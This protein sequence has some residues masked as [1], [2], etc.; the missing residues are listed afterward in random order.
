MNITI[1]RPNRVSLR[2]VCLFLAALLLVLSSCALSSVRPDVPRDRPVPR[3]PDQAVKDEIVDTFERIRQNFRV[4]SSSYEEIIREL[5]PEL[6]YGLVNRGEAILPE[7]LSLI[8]ENLSN[9]PGARYTM[10]CRDILA[11]MGYTEFPHP[12]G[13]KGWFEVHGIAFYEQYVG[14]YRPPEKPERAWDRA[15][16]YCLEKGYFNVIPA[17]PSVYIPEPADPNNPPYL[18]WETMLGTWVAWDAYY[19]EELGFIIEENPVDH[20]YWDAIMYPDG[21]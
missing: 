17:D 11:N 12:G 5:E 2:A 7:V 15:N 6:Y 18:R 4:S 13:G 10:L 21:R 9:A 3:E 16:A 19:D 8:A 20:E 1:K 14:P